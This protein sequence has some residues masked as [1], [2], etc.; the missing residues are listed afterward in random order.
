MQD[1]TFLVVCR[2]FWNVEVVCNVK[3]HESKNVLAN[4]YGCAQGAP[5]TLSPQLVR[6]NKAAQPL[7][8]RAK[9]P[10]KTPCGSAASTL[11]RADK[12]SVVEGD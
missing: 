6:Q 1:S 11:R 9:I 10:P 8:N 5:K 12:V 4:M 7:R 3:D 2:M